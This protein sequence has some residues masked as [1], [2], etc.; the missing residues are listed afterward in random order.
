M[1][2]NNIQEI[3]DCFVKYKNFQECIIENIRFADYFTTIEIDINNIWTND[4]R[5]RNNLDT[6]KEIVQLRFKR[7]NN[8]KI[9]NDLNDRILS[10]LDKINWG[11]N[12]VALARLEPTENNFIKVLF[13]WENNRVIE[14]IFKDLELFVV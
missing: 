7:L 2:V 11:F 13:Q 6:K 4:G 5:I 1:V 9:F 14:I 10:E 3:K 8:F 12:E